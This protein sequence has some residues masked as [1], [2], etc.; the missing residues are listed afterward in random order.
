PPDLIR[1]LLR[2]TERVSIEVLQHQ[3]ELLAVADAVVGAGLLREDPGFY[4]VDPPCPEEL[5]ELFQD[6]LVPFLDLYP[7]DHAE[8]LAAHPCAATG[9]RTLP[10]YQPG[11]VPG[12]KQLSLHR[13]S[14][15]SP[16][17]PVKLFR[18]RI[19]PRATPVVVGL[20]YERDPDTPQVEA[21]R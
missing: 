7:E 8:V 14:L 2:S 17:Y 18:A 6:G 15:V 13:K 20:A 11:H 21:R 5:L 12:I 3:R 19:V 9:E 4:V 1:A 16:P 10:L